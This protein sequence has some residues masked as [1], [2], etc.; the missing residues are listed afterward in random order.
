M[1]D[2]RLHA[3]LLAAAATLA[4][5]GCGDGDPE[6]A[7]T[8]PQRTVDSA[9]VEDQI[10]E[11]LATPTTEVSKVG[12]PEDVQPAAGATFTCSVTWADGAKGKVEVTQESAARFTYAPV[13]GSVRVPG[14][15]VEAS[16]E[17]ALAEQGA[18]GVQA[19]CPD[20]VTVKEGSTVTCT[21]QGASGVAGGTVSF[22]FS[23]ATGTVDPTTVQAG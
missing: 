14:K 13:P 12:C 5:A 6:A 9:Q 17:R 4:L 1:V 11:Q 7:A 20:P 19:S 3:A 2:R 16:V 18:P 10:T 23:D 15:T 8:T 21:V 22:S